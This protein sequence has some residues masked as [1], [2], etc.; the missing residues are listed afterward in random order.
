MGRGQGVH[1]DPKKLSVTP[2]GG[3]FVADDKL[4]PVDVLTYDMRGDVDRVRRVLNGSVTLRDSDLAADVDN[5]WED[6]VEVDGHVHSGLAHDY[7]F[8]NF[9]QLV[10]DIKNLRIITLVH[11]VNV[12]NVVSASQEDLDTFY[13]N[14]F[15]CPRCASDG[16]GVLVYGEGIG[17]GFAIGGSR[18]G[19]WSGGLDIVAHE[20]TH[21]VT[22]LTSRLGSS[23]EAGALNEAFSDIMGTSIEFFFQDPGDGP[24]KADYL[25]G[26]DV[27]D[28]PRAGLNRSLADPQRFGDPDHW[29]KRVV[30]SADNGGVHTNSLIASHAFYLAVEGGTNRTS[31]VTVQGVG[32]AQQHQM[33]EVFFRAFAFMLSSN[34]TFRLARLATIQAASDLDPSGGLAS[35]LTQAWNAVGVN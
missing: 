29:S 24:L 13:L 16:N 10:T 28:P 5:V 34:S 31:G 23:N 9:G 27:T 12:E 32:R 15:F 7:N 26:E 4:R 19:P 14:S 33:T 30:G 17:P 6:P 25:I 20:F 8:R 21:L 1:G 22:H 11:P 18:V 35:A 2:S 3:E